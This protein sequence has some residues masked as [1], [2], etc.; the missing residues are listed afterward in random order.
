MSEKNKNYVFRDGFNYPRRQ[1]RLKSSVLFGCS[2][3]SVKLAM[4]FAVSDLQAFLKYLLELSVL[5]SVTKLISVCRHEK[6]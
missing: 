1:I 3:H 6:L 4:L 2:M 5:R